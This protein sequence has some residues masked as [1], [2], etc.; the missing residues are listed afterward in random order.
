MSPIKWRLYFI[1]Y[2]EHGDSD[3]ALTGPNMICNIKITI[4]DSLPFNDK[5]D[6]QYVQFDMLSTDSG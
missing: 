2:S 1:V 4:Y 3:N 6:Y 5:E